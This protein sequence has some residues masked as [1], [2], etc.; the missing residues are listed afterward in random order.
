VDSE[1]QSND[2]EPTKAAAESDR[3]DLEWLFV[4]KHAGL[5]FA[6][7]NELRIRDLAVFVDFKTSNRSGGRRVATQPDIDRFYG[8]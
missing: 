7:M 5:S 3:P 1:D 6:E 4:G 8:M 2:D